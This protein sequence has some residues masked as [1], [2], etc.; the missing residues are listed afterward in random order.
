M[1]N[2]LRTLAATL[3]L[4]TSCRVL[5]ATPSFEDF[6]RRAKEGEKLV[7][8]FF[9]ASLTWGANATDQAYTSYRAQLA[10]R[11]LNSYPKAHF[12]FHDGAIGGTGSQLGVFRLER[13]ALRRK[14]DLVFLDFSANDDIYSADPETLASYESLVRR[15]IQ[16]GNC[17]VVQVIFPFG[18][19]VKQGNTGGMK[20]RDAHIAIAEAY[21]A[22]VG[23]AITLGI[24]R[25]KSGAATIEKIWPNDQV[26]PGDFGY[27]LFTD[28]A[29]DAFQKG[30]KDKV[31]CHVPEKMLHA[32]T[33]MTQ[34]RVRL[35]TL[36]PLPEGWSVTTPDL[37]AA[38]HDAVMSRWLDD[39]VCAANTKK[40][41]DADG[42][43]K[44]EPQKVAR[45]KFKVK[46]KVLMLFGESTLKS[47]QYRVLIDGNVHK[48]TP[49]GK[50]DETDLYDAESRMGGNTHHEKV[51]TATLDP[52]V[53]HLIEIE[54]VFVDG[55]GQELKL[56]SV[57]VAGGAAKVLA[58]P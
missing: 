4:A 51:I 31:V 29:W 47:A 39:I 5:A 14:P 52:E 34:S 25:V 20:R 45:F 28:A 35:A 30:V 38:W 8:V 41:K 32:D 22:M 27:G 9:G 19:N 40:V 6:D 37:T 17:P 53:E 26:H 16:Q 44:T 36:Q 49:W 50:K 42:K 21:G 55:K 43:D 7:V 11:M 23:D 54:P 10:D 58:A 13:D 1:R 2:I 18:W 33:Y 24:E 57:C 46:A 48:Y 3:M 12:T 56:E 15:L